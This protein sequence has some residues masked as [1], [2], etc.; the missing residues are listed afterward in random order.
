MRRRIADDPL[1]YAR[2]PLEG[3]EELRRD[4]EVFLPTVADE[5][6]QERVRAALA[7]TRPRR[8]Y[9]DALARYPEEQRRWL[10]FAER[11]LADRVV[12]WLA[13]VGVAPDLPPRRR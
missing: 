4:G 9:F 13:S 11:R 6:L 10:D 7:S 3:D 5:D 1:R 2:V 8:R 12:A